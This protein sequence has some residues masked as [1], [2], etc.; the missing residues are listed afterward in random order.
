MFFDADIKGADLPARTLVLTYDD[1]PGPR[2]AELGRYLSGEHIQATFFVI[3]RHAQ[4]RLETLA[5]LAEG[6]HTIGNHT[7]SH[8]GLVALAEGGG[9]V[10][11]E[12]ARTDAIIRDFT[13]KRPIFFRAPYGNWRQVDPSTNLDKPRSIVAEQLN[14][15]GRLR[16]TI[17]P[18]NWDISAEDFAF[19]RR[20]ASATEAAEAYLREIGKVGRGIVLLHDSSDDSRI[21]RQNRTLEL[22]MLLVPQLKLRGYRFVPIQKL[23]A[24]KEILAKRIIATRSWERRHVDARNAPHGGDDH[25]Q[26]PGR[27]A[28]L[29]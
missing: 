18:V 19:W 13:D 10:V 23:P 12:L 7:Y 11:A 22:T 5:A 15:S 4:E 9:D 21:A 26:S 24:V 20:G 8:P 25:L 3:G 27:D 2:T 14:R 16:D 1:G 6:G 29:A 28:S 17:G